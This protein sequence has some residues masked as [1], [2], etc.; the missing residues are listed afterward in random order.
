MDGAQAG[1]DVD[2]MSNPATASSPRH[3]PDRSRLVKDIALIGSVWAASDLGFYLLLPALGIPTSYNAGA[4]AITLYYGFWAGVAVIAFWPIYATWPRHARWNT[5]ENRVHS[6]VLWTVA[7][8]G[9]VLFAAHVLPS[10]PRVVWPEDWAP[11]EFVVASS[12]YFLPKTIDILFQQLLIIALVLALAAQRLPLRRIAVAC[13]LV[14]GGSHVMLAFGDV[15][16]LY[17]ARFMLSAGLFGLVFPF[18]ILRVR[19]GLAYSYMLHW[20]YYAMSVMLPHI[21]LA[22]PR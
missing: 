14:F 21:F 12:W 4:M 10:L 20:G 6:L 5:F 13:A 1:R 3:G 2:L 16:L 7:Y 17:V 19:N 8:V 11:P 15:P 18:F 9:C 22:S